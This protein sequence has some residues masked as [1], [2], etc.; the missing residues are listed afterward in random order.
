MAASLTVQ[1]NSKLVLLNPHYAKYE[2]GA[3]RYPSHDE[4]ARYHTINFSSSD[5]VIAGGD[6]TASEY[7]Q[8]LVSNP[9]ED[10]TNR[11]TSHMADSTIDSAGVGSVDVSG[12]P[13][14]SNERNVKTS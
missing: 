14:L 12:M 4:N 8:T 3:L 13:Y 9:G 5:G 1:Q 11:A 7:D 6:P 2:S 10:Y